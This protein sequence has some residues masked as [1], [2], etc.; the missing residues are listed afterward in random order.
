MLAMAK[1]TWVRR[2]GLGM[3]LNLKITY[4]ESKLD[5]RPR[6]ESRPS[7]G[8]RLPGWFACLSALSGTAARAGPQNEPTSSSTNSRNELRR[9]SPRE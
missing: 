1:C 3:L 7:L 8:I 2:S 5:Y 4:A 9:S 6:S